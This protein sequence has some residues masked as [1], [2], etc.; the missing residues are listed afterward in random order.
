MTSLLLRAT[1]L[2]C[3]AAAILSA[4][5]DPVSQSMQAGAAGGGGTPG[6]GAGGAATCASLASGPLDRVDGLP[7]PRIDEIAASV[8]IDL[9]EAET[10]KNPN[11]AAAWH[12]LARAYSAG[13]AVDEMDA[14]VYG[15]K[16]QDAMR[17]AAS[18]GEP[19]E[20]IRV[21]SFGSWQV[22]H[23]DEVVA[24][25]E[26]AIASVSQKAGSSPAHAL[27]VATGRGVL[28]SVTNRRDGAAVLR[29]NGD[30]A[31][32]SAIKQAATKIGWEAVYDHY[33]ELMVLGDCFYKAMCIDYFDAIRDSGDARV[34]LALGVDNI[35]YAYRNTNRAFA[36]AGSSTQAR[37]KALTAGDR[38]VDSAR[39]FARLAV[40]HG[41]PQEQAA[42]N[43]LLKA[44]TAFEEYRT[45]R[46]GVEGDQQAR[47]EAEGWKTVAGLVVAAIALSGDGKGGNRSSEYKIEP[48]NWAEEQRQRDCNMAQGMMVHRNTMSQNDIHAFTS[49]EMAS[50]Y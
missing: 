30:A 17:R 4:C 20:A 48:T 50:C 49:M 27:A 35:T 26:Q 13:M 1:P 24:P 18:L 40:Q 12:Y 23:I 15:P 5:S 14:N 21:A 3:L 46:Y 28:L 9:C 36:F 29:G 34:F 33:F 37:M 16:A 42:A 8:A 44:A 45:E 47:A 22:R 31:M 39:G 10:Q 38:S 43:D 25:L 2:A 19:S 6:S 7:G 32:M 41:D 11:E